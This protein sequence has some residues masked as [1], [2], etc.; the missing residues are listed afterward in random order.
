MDIHVNFEEMTTEDL[1]K[2]IEAVEKGLKLLKMLS[3]LTSTKY[4][5]TAVEVA[6]KL[7]TMVKEYAKEPW[8]LDLLKVVL[9]LLRKNPRALIPMLEDIA[10]RQGL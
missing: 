5:D 9:N 6:E 1:V 4:D 10:Q 7:V 3:S 8:C 2:Y